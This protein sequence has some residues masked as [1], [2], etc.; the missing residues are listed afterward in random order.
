MTPPSVPGKDDP[1]VLK[2]K[3]PSC[4]IVY[5]I[6]Q[7]SITFFPAVFKCRKC[8][9]RIRIEA[10]AKRP[11][12]A[13]LTPPR[14]LV[15][16]VGSD[17]KAP[18]SPS[19]APPGGNTNVG[20]DAF[21][22]FIGK[23]ASLYL[24]RF[25][26]FSADGVTRYAPTW[27]WPAFLV[28]WLW[29]LYRKLYLWSLIAFVTGLIPLV[30][31]AARVAWGMTAHYIFYKHTQKKI[32]RIK[33]SAG[34]QP[35]MP[36]NQVLRKQGGVHSWVWGVSVVPLIGILAAIA[37]PQF[38]L[39]RTRAFDAQAK[40]AVQRVVEA[41]Q[42]Y[43]LQNH[44]Y[45]DSIEQLQSVGLD[46][47]GVPELEISVLGAGPG[48]YYVESFH[49][50]GN[51]R[52]AA[53]AADDGVAVLPRASQE[54][55]GPNHAFVLT[56]PEDWQQVNN[57]NSVAELQIAQA[58]KD[59]YVIVIAEKQEDLP[60]TELA[61]YSALARNGI[62]QRLLQTGVHETGLD[63]IN[64][65]AAVQYEIRGVL[66]DNQVPLVYL[67]TAVKGQQHYYQI[68]AWTTIQNYSANQS[69]IKSIVNHFREI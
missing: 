31:L 41:Q 26:H 6:K 28:P 50:K 13:G 66:P 52:F 14:P 59:C 47:R 35:T 7:A 53:C 68:I 25:K 12:A 57:L 45:S 3:C 30:N 62:Q 37:I 18:P 58:S 67:H 16:V 60:G 44:Q 65:C 20:S 51:K 29:F 48:N 55:F 56:V 5:S 34:L 22:P 64:H 21:V 61:D 2:I 11:A 54:F 15:A 42:N 46:L 39:Y 38:N 19:A 4:G 8:G 17:A 24:Q 69:T 27:H 10:P 63:S 49:T 1:A 9:H 33:E 40:A 32:G 43:Y 23:N 36:L